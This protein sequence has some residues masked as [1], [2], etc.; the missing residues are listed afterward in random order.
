[1]QIDTA[2]LFRS[3]YSYAATFNYMF[4]GW[5]AYMAGSPPNLEGSLDGDLDTRPYEYFHPTQVSTTLGQ[6]KRKV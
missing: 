1:M 6:Y 5:D 3:N 2:N 4:Y